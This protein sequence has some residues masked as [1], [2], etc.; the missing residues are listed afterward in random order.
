MDESHHV[1][2]IQCGHVTSRATLEQSLSAARTV[3]DLLD[4]LPLDGPNGIRRYHGTPQQKQ[5]LRACCNCI[6]MLQTALDAIRRPPKGEEVEVVL[7]MPVT[8]GIGR[9][10]ED[11]AVFA[12]RLALDPPTIERGYDVDEFRETL[13]PAIARIQE[14]VERYRDSAAGAQNDAPVAATVK[15]SKPTLRFTPPP[16][17][18]CDGKS[19]V[20]STARDVRKLKCK[21]CEHTWQ[22]TR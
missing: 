5:T 19:R 8:I 9:L 4:F 13:D 10:G 14:V 17:P 7:S 22:V 6:E 2:G 15:S 1:A 16:C 12:E 18:I 11:A 20:Q 21:E 3:A